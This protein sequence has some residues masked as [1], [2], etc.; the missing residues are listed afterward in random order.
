MQG[1]NEFFDYIVT[2]STERGFLEGSLRGNVGLFPA[3]CVQEIRMKNYEKHNNHLA[4]P[5]SNHRGK[6]GS[7]QAAAAAAAVSR[8]KKV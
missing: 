3:P 6:G 1:M 4:P 7:K 5:S 2:G 8:I